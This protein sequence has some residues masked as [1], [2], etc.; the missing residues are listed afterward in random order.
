M[1]VITVTDQ[2]MVGCMSEIMCDSVDSVLRDK[3]QN[4]VTN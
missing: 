1:V 2:P 3:R 4:K